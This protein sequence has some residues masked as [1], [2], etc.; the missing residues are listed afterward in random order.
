MHTEPRD[1]HI[2][3][4]AA[5]AANLVIAVAKLAA[6]LATRSSAM[7]SESIHSVVDTGNELLLLRAS[8]AAAGRPMRCI[9]SDM[10]RSSTSGA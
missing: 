4:Y 8:G 5:I 9:R 7:L 10:V 1:R 3:V 2:T 6:A